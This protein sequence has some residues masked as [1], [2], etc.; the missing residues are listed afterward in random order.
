[1]DNSEPSIISFCGNWC[2]CSRADIGG[3]S[4]I[5][6]PPNL[7][8]IRLMHSRAVAPLHN[9]EALEPEATGAFVGG[10][11]WNRYQ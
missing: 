5:Q 7:M 1:M 9:L 8:M 3:V 4:R 2:T 6:D 10:Y 11:H